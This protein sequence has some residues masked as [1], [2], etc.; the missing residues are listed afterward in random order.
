M[1]SAARLKPLY[2]RCRVENGEFRQALE[3]KWIPSSEVDRYIRA[4]RDGR[5][6]RGRTVDNG[7]VRQAL[8]RAYFSEAEID[9]ILYG[10]EPE[11]K[12]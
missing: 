7:E 10:E 3:K 11:Q 6:L 8:S 5:P 2:V 12:V 1:P 9:L 4:I